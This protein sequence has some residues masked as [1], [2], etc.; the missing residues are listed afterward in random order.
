MKTLYMIKRVAV[1]AHT[2][3]LKNCLNVEQLLDSKHELNGIYDFEA[4]TV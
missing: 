2:L 1:L 4:L 3:Y